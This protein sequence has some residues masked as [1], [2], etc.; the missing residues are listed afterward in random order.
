MSKLSAHTYKLL[1]EVFPHH[2][3]IE[4]CYVRYEGQRLFFDFFIKELDVFIECQGR[5]HDEYV[6]HF[7]GDREGFLAHKKRDNLKKAYCEENDSYFVEI[8]RELN[9]DELK[10]AIWSVMKKW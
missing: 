2:R 9:S 10:N 5:Q 6:A 1:K 4:E 8:R 7:H 3:I